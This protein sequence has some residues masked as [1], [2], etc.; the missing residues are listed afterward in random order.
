MPDE[1]PATGHAR[2]PGTSTSTVSTASIT[3]SVA[4]SADMNLDSTS[5]SFTQ[6]SADQTANLRPSW[7][8]LCVSSRGEPALRCRLSES[9]RSFRV[10]RRERT[11]CRAACAAGRLTSGNRSGCSIDSTARSTSSAG[12]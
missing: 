2:R 11:R 12:Q 7:V 8:L 6:N 10:A 1:S 4:L 3:I 9:Y 5:Y